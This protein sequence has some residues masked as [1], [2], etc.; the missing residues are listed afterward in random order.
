MVDRA[1][2]E[3]CKAVRICFLGV[4]VAVFRI[5]AVGWVVVMVVH[6]RFEEV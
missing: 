4:R 1:S 2:L 5:E 3:F 6:S